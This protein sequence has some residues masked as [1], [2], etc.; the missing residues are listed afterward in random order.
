MRSFINSRSCDL[1]FLALSPMVPTPSGSDELEA[2]NAMLL[3]DGSVFG[4]AH[5]T[6]AGSGSGT[7]I[8]HNK[9]G[10]TTGTFSTEL[11]SLNLS[12]STAF[13]P[14]LI[15]ESPT[16]ASL[17][18]TSIIA[19]G[20]GQF[21][22]SSFFDVFTELSID[23]GATWVPDSSGPERITLMGPVPEPSAY[24]LAGLA[25]GLLALKRARWF[26]K[27]TVIQD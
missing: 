11:L 27:K 14:L 7:M 24:A 4:L 23:G 22:I 8:T 26:G 10:N 25:A 15:R 12:G 19:L 17:G 1:G 2:F 16:L 18:Q 20:G 9:I 3:G 13:G 21:Q 6:Y 5:L